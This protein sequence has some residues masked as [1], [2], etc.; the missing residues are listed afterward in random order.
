[1]DEDYAF[2]LKK[3]GPA[4]EQQAVP[5]SSIERYKKRLPEQ[6]LKYWEV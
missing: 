4:I 6:L 2:F 1:M 3:F 5:T